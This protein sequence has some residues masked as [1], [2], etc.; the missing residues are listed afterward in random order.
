M[1]LR[2]RHVNKWQRCL[3]PTL[4]F[5][6]WT[7]RH[8]NPASDA[9]SVRADAVWLRNTPLAIRIYQR[10]GLSFFCVNSHNSQIGNY[11]VVLGRRRH[12]HCQY[13]YLNGLARTA[14]GRSL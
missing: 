4:S 6:G 1:Q 11:Y 3:Q 12:T 9:S 10:R 5:V 13:A 14:F 8:A 2:L 7:T